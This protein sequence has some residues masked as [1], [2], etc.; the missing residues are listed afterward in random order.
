VK[1]LSA[2]NAMFGRDGTQ[3]LISPSLE[4]NWRVSATSNA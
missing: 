1:D 4:L 3:R 2:P